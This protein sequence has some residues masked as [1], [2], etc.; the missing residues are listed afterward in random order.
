MNGSVK[1]STRTPA[2][3][4]MQRGGDLAGEL[5]GGV[6]VEDVVERA[7]QRDQRRAGQDHPPA[8]VAHGR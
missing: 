8:V 6:Q 1:S 7:D 3:T 2:S 4:G 5:D